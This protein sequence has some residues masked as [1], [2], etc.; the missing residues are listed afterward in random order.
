M[1][2]PHHSV[3]MIQMLFLQPNQQ[4][5]STEGTMVWPICSKN[6]P[7]IKR[8]GQDVDYLIPHQ[9]RRWSSTVVITRHRVTCSSDG[10]VGKLLFQFGDGPTERFSTLNDRPDALISHRRFTTWRTCNSRISMV[11]TPTLWSVAHN[12]HTSNRTWL[13]LEQQPTCQ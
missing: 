12:I 8:H 2:V 3:F 4:H 9:H 11:L 6:R 7:P 13:R 1:P 5:Q 10:H